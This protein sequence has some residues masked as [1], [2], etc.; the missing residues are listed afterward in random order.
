MRGV[1]HIVGGPPTVNAGPRL[2]PHQVLRILHDG[3]VIRRIR[4]DGDARFRTRLPP[5]VYTIS[6]FFITPRILRVGTTAVSVRLTVN[7]M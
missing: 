5:G 7:A 4:A 3:A 2:E 6:P 1:V